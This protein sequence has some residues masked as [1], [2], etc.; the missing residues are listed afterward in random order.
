MLTPLINILENYIFYISF[1]LFVQ[2]IYIP[3]IE[4]K[5]NYTF[6]IVN[7]IYRSCLYKLMNYYAII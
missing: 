4:Y 1:K 5:N 7:Y 2:Q 6:K 3:V